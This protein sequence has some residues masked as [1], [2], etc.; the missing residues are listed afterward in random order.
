MYARYIGVSIRSQMQYRASF[1]LFTIASFLGTG[2]E[3]LS[4][5]V[6]FDRFGNLQGWRMAEVAL[7]YGMAHVAFAVTEGVT[8][9]LDVFHLM[10]KSGDFDRLLLRPRTTLLQLLGQELQLMRLGRLL[11]GL[12]VLLW[13]G[14]AL[15]VSWS[16]PRLALLIGTIAGA[17]CMFGG[18]IIIQ[19]TLAFWTTESLEVVNCAT[20]G[21]VYAAEY[22][23]AIYR[24]WFRR[25]FT[26]VVPLACVC[27]LPGLAILGRV[28]GPR[29]VWHCL[30]PLAGVVFLAAAVQLWKL[31]VRHYRSTGS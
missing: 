29:L 24:R 4:I 16:L 11:Q 10:V 6:L 23:L 13:A 30:S 26:F 2:I 12:A 15:D 27:Y 5:W 22:P 31:G 7:F 18:L 1:M 21:G 19:A 8:R 9:G 17:A 20:Y 28:E 25:F 14:G 3:F